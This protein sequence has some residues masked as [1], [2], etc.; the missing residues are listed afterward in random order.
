MSYCSCSAYMYFRSPWIRNDLDFLIMILFQSN[1]GQG[2]LFRDIHIQ[3]ELDKLI[4]EHTLDL[5]RRR[6]RS[7][8][9]TQNMIYTTIQEYFYNEKRIQ[10]HP[11]RLVLITIAYRST[12]CAY[13]LYAAFKRAGND[14]NVV[15]INFDP[16]FHGKSC[17]IQ[18]RSVGTTSITVIHVPADIY[19]Q[20]GEDI[21]NFGNQVKAA[22][23]SKMEKRCLPINTEDQKELLRLYVVG[24]AQNQMEADIISKLFAYI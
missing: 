8:Y 15:A 22:V 16:Y 14:I 13:M 19:T 5:Q 18:P 2:R 10:I 3:K 17:E 20:T 24:P 6:P 23:K 7:N 4:Q 9:K 12:R 1:T 11:K 21:T